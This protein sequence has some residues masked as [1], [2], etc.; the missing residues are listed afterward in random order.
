VPVGIAA[1]AM[2]PMQSVSDVLAKGQEDSVYPAMPQIARMLI[3]I[4]LEE[5]HP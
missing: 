1:H 5:L 4:R 2:A 3:Q